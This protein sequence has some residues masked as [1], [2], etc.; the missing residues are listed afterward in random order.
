MVIDKETFDCLAI[1]VANAGVVQGAMP[2]FINGDDDSRVEEGL[3]PI[4]AKNQ[5]PD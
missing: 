2:T 1:T 4:K 5:S 3:P